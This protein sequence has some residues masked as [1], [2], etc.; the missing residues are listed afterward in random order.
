MKIIREILNVFTGLVIFVSL[1]VGIPST[2]S[3]ISGH[4]QDTQSAIIF[5]SIIIGA[6]VLCYYLNK[7]KNDNL[8][9]RFYNTK[10]LT[11]I[12]TFAATVACLSVFFVANLLVGFFVSFVLLAFVL[13]FVVGPL[14]HCP[15][16][17]AKLPY[18]KRGKS[19]F[20]I[21]EC[22][23]CEAVLSKP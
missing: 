7:P 22:P 3:T 8:L 18:L 19:G 1:L 16:C 23:N 11:S 9:Q 14:W 17:E 20:S 15:K 5:N 13:N 4:T 6:L 10:W 12:S 2:V 21:K